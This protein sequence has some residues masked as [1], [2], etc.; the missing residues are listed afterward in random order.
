MSLFEEP[1]DCDND[2]YPSQDIERWCEAVEIQGFVIHILQNI[3]LLIFL[4]FKENV[5]L[6]HYGCKIGKYSFCFVLF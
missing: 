3:C 1:R 2:R 4:C 5:P 6:M